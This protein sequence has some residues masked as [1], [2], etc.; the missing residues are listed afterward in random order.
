MGIEFND[1]QI[2]ALYDIEN[3]WNIQ[4]HQVY[5]LSG[6]AGTGKAQPIDT[7]IPTPNGDIKLG[8]LKIGD[9]VFNRKGEPVKVLGIYDQGKLD[10]YKVTFEDGRSTLCNDRH[11]WSYYTSKGNLKTD[12]LKNMA[13]KPLIKKDGCYRYGVP[14]AKCVEYTRKE[15]KI[16]P[17]VIG[18]FIG[19]S[20]KKRIPKEYF[21]GDEEQ[22]WSL[23]QGL[24]DTDGD[25]ILS[26]REPIRYTSINKELVYDIKLLL[27][28][29]GYASTIIKDS[30][31]NKD[32]GDGIC[33]NLYVK[34]DNISK[35]KFFRIK[36]KKN[37]ALRIS[38][39]KNNRDYTK[40]YIYSIENL[41]YKTDMRCIYVDDPEHLYLTNDYIVT[42]NT[43]LI[44]YFIDR[45]GM[46]LDKVAFVA[47][48]GKAA[49][50]MARNGLPAQTIHSLIYTY[51]KVLDL[52]EKGNIQIKDNGKPKTKF[53]FVKKEK[54]HK[55]VKLIV[56]D[57]ASMVNEEIAMDLLSYGIPIIA[58]G[59]LNQLPPVFGNPFFLKE[60]DFILTQVMRQN[61]NN[62]I[63]WLAHNVLNDLPLQYGV[64]GKS[65][66][67][68]K[69]DMNEF[70][71][72]RADIVLTCTNKLRGEINTLFRE[73][74]K[75]IKRLDLPNEGEKVI[76]RKNNWSRSINDMIFMTNGMTGTVDYVDIES[77]NG[78]G[79]KCD[80]KP[81]FIKKKFKNVVFDYSR[82]FS[83]PGSDISS[84]LFSFTRDQFE[85]AYAITV[86]L[87]QG[88]QYSNVVFLNER[89]MYDKETYKKLQY[90]A[91]T[92]AID[93]IQIL[94]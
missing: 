30:R 36:R 84:D 6:A 38:N 46:D 51:E 5:N 10:V 80:F 56:V 91:I 42:H 71:L 14:M 26:N 53:Q 75:R 60:P 21:Y 82:L 47:Y 2:Y 25:I 29:L 67:I 44:R 20:H 28:S 79:I 81:D 19:P 9:Y 89:M 22:R 52:D 3:W 35:S 92:R 69:S 55:N 83:Q 12:S 68:P 39:N 40:S 17:Y 76:C 62:P 93:S 16:D 85:F 24:F 77:F 15:F 87:S 74:I 8:D 59:D 65:S 41:G 63:I 48:M 49:M 70:M 37:I 72:N 43:T 61:E 50:Q 11:L 27:A 58:L 78:K 33:Y 4:N 86:H 94:I 90:T 64:Y 23:I 18:S 45:I 13:K 34:T 7:I 54:L 32:R 73:R 88:S 66:V 57:E 1:Q 31:L